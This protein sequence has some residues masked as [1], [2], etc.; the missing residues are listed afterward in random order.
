LLADIE[1]ERLANNQRG[2]DGPAKTDK[3]ESKTGPPKNAAAPRLA[4]R[5]GSETKKSKKKTRNHHR[6]PKRHRNPKRNTR[7]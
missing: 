2:V 6:K 7:H 4:P 5:K 3:K 1:S